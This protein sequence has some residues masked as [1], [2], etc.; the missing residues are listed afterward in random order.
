MREALTIATA[1]G[2]FSAHVA[3]PATSKAVP[4]A[5]V[6]HEVFGVNADMRITCDELAARGFIAIC[7]DLFWRQAPGVDLSVTS[8]ADWNIGVALYTSYDRDAG[9]GDVLA[10]LRA[11]D[12]LEAAN[13]KVAVMGY[14]LGGLMAFLT[15]ARGSVDAAVAY[16]GGDTESYLD[17]AASI[18]A[19]MLMHLAG[20]DE[21][22][23][24]DAQVRIKAAL[25]AKEQVE[26]FSYASCNHAFSRHGGSHYDPA[27]ATI[28]NTRTL[29][30][31]SKHLTGGAR[32]TSG[33]GRR[34]RRN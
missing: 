20:E 16:H 30:F 7:P 17:E 33:A 2:D 4:V 19:P 23:S 18:T 14:C 11:A 3:R 29:A 26:I 13:G 21:F 28:A 22:M 9:V 5:V 10:T 25:A 31:L 27:A 34:R 15:A 1:D 12:N 24:K 32:L 6:L 8:A